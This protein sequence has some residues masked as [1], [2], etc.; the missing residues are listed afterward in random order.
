M[1]EQFGNN[2][3]EG[4]IDTDNSTGLEHIDIQLNADEKLVKDLESNGGPRPNV[5]ST[6]THQAKQA[7]PV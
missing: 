7:T 1:V 6:T 2:Y 3:Q 5:T 4:K